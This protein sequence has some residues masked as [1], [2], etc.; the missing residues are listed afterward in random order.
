MS[1]IA[2]VFERIRVKAAARNS[3]NERVYRRMYWLLER[4]CRE[5]RGDIGHAR[6]H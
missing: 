1:G 2:R 4:R 5:V 6:L 3:L